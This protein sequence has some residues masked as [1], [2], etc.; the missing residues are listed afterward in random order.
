MAKRRRRSGTGW[1]F[2]TPKSANKR[3]Y[4][5]VYSSNVT[6]KQVPK[7]CAIIR[8]GPKK[9]KLRRGCRFRGGHAWCDTIVADKIDTSK[10]RSAVPRPLVARKRRKKSTKRLTSGGSKKSLQ[11]R[12]GRGRSVKGLRRR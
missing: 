4:Q 3:S 5:K 9:G 6:S 1:M 8:S 11:L 7:G 2:L 12:E 10:C